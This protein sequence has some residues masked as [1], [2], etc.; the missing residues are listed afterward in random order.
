MIF[1]NLPIDVLLIQERLNESRVL[2]PGSQLEKKLTCL[3]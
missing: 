1:P 3:Y 2:V